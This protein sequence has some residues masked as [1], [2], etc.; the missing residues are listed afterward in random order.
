M[1]NGAAHNV[2]TFSRHRDTRK[3]KIDPNIQN[4]HLKKKRIH[5]KDTITLSIDP[6]N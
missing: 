5:L 1:D 6:A 4:I 3:K 2:V